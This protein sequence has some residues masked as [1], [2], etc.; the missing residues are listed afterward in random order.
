M[1]VR[2]PYTVIMEDEGTGSVSSEVMHAPQD[3]VAARRYVTMEAP[4]GKH[5]VAMV[6]G[7]CPV[8]HGLPGAV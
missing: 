1:E 6:R 4:E 7:L 2:V 5:V 8:I 3:T